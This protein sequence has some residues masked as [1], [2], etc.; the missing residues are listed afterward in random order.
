MP[1]YDSDFYR[2]EVADSGDL[3]ALVTNVTPDLEIVFRLW[4]D[5]DSLLGDW[6]YPLAAGGNTEGLFTIA[7][8]GVYYL[9]VVDN[10]NNRSIQ[11]YLLRLSMDE[12]DPTAL[13][14]SQST[15][16]TDVVTDTVSTVEE[17]TETV[18]ATTTILTTTITVQ[19]SGDISESAIVTATDAVSQTSVVTRPVS[20]GVTPPSTP[21]TPGGGKKI[22]KPA[23]PVTPTEEITETSTITMTPEITPTSEISETSTTSDTGSLLPSQPAPAACRA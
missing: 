1:A 9:E 16:S 8:P 18:T 15:T 13:T 10:N 12:I 22:V 6:V 17:G 19:A 11:P 20:S 23:E 21:G 3:H 7:T 5:N 4:D 2:I 14:Y